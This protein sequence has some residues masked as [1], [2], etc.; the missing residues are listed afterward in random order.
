MRFALV[1]LALGKRLR[2]ILK[3][4][5]MLGDFVNLLALPV[6]AGLARNRC[7][8]LEHDRD[9]KRIV[10]VPAFSLLEAMLL[11]G[12]SMGLANRMRT[13]QHSGKDAGLSAAHAP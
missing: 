8:A 3:E 11:L 1:D 6:F 13:D 12:A 9:G 4:V 2:P 5:G 7:R 10:P